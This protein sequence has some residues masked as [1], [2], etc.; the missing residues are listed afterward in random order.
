MRIFLIYSDLL[1]ISKSLMT[2]LMLEFLNK[3]CIDKNGNN[4]YLTDEVLWPGSG[5]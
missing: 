4:F 2:I 5:F 3:L 1:V